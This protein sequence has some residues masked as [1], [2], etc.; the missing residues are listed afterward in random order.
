MRCS[1]RELERG[2][3]EASRKV[4]ARSTKEKRWDIA[5][6]PPR[7]LSQSQHICGGLALQ[8]AMQRCGSAAQH[9]RADEQ[10]GI[11]MTTANLPTVKECPIRT[12]TDARW[13]DR[14]LASL[15]PPLRRASN[16]TALVRYLEVHSGTWMRQS[17]L[18]PVKRPT[19][20]GFT[21]G[22]GI[23]TL[24]VS[25]SPSMLRFRT[26]AECDVG[27]VELLFLF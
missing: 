17:R 7:A 11:K 20:T 26:V 22:P 19:G 2:E 14:D 27:K 5:P 8:G 3:M 18:S 23:Y 21:H 9:Q 25:F 6:L 16:I 15:V 1:T 4:E 13:D 10:C 12:R 24:K